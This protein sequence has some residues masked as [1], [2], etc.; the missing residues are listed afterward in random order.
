MLL[1]ARD[2][3]STPS[4]TFWNVT[5]ISPLA[6]GPSRS[7]PRRLQNI[8]R[9]CHGIN[10]ACP[11]C[12]RLLARKSTHS[13]QSSLKSQS[14]WLHPLHANATLFCEQGRSGEPCPIVGRKESWNQ[15]CCGL[16]RCRSCE[17]SPSRNSSLWCHLLP[18]SKIARRQS[19]RPTIAVTVSTRTTFR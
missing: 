15:Q 14:R 9:G 7:E 12:S 1:T 19:C 11:D 4:G 8:C 3:V 16:L 5:G 17:S 13:G 10:P 6:E 2:S 18:Y